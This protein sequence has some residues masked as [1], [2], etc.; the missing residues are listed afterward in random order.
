MKSFITCTWLR[1]LS[2][3]CIESSSI[4][5]QQP[6]ASIEISDQRRSEAVELLRAHGVSEEESV[7]AICPGSINSRAKRWPSEGYATL[8]DRLID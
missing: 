7:V 4:C 3:C 6:D 2:S 5:E 1:H 8:A